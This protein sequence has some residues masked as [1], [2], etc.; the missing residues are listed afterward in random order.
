MSIMGVVTSAAAVNAHLDNLSTRLEYVK[1]SQ[2]STL[3]A[4]FYALPN[5]GGSVAL[6]WDIVEPLPKGEGG[7]IRFRCKVR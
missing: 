1:G 7:V 2:S 3:E 4:D 5:K 6:R